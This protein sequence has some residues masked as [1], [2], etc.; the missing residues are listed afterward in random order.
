[1]LSALEFNLLSYLQRVQFGISVTTLGEKTIKTPLNTLN[2]Q[3]YFLSKCL[4]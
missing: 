3:W 4:E 1:M 2:K